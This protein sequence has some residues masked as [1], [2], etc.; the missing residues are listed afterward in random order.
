MHED[1]EKQNRV[2]I[3]RIKIGHAMC[4]YATTGSSIKMYKKYK[5]CLW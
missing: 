5:K 1:A 3:S 2:E 4:R